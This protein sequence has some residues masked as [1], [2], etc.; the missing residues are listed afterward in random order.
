MV[1]LGYWASL[2]QQATPEDRQIETGPPPQAEGTAPVAEHTPS[3]EPEPVSLRITSAPEGAAISVGGRGTG[4]L[5]PAEVELDPDSEHVLEL[6]LNGYQ[7]AGWSF[8]LE[9]LD[10]EQRA[11]GCLHFPLASRVPP[12]MITVNA[13]YPVS[14][15]VDGQ[16]HGPFSRGEVPV[17]PGRHRVVLVAKDVF[18]RQTS[19][20]EIASGERRS[21]RVPKAV[22]V[23]ITANPANCEVSVDG[24]FV[25]VTPI[26]D[27][28]LVVGS[29]ELSFYWPALDVRKPVR[30]TVSRE[31]QRISETPN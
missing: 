28:R 13:P 4:L 1:A 16:P 29:H 22:T 3:I 15:V 6:T 27:R 11:C 26:N 24:I 19:E 31:G 23:L 12:G 18:L 2:R 9:D 10:Q 7:P 20:V 21:L 14:L 17:T 8:R 30:K 5:T 25:D